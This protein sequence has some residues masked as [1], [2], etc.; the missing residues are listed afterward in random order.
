MKDLDVDPRNLYVSL[1]RNR[2]LMCFDFQSIENVLEEI[3]YLQQV[4]ARP[5]S[6]ITR[7][8]KVFLVA[9]TTLNKTQRLLV[10]ME[11]IRNGLNLYIQIHHTSVC[12][13]DLL[14]CYP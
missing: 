4:V 12:E 2:Q 5:R 9:K 1:A 6:K 3:I 11:R 10:S 8:L 7:V 13:E 14:T